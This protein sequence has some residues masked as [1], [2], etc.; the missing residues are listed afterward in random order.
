[1][2]QLDDAHAA[3]Q[4]ER[5]QPALTLDERLVAERT[6]RSATSISRRMSSSL[7]AH[8]AADQHVIDERA[9]GPPRCVHVHVD[10][11]RL[12]ARRRSRPRRDVCET[13]VADRGARWRRDRRRAAADKTAV[14]ASAPSSGRRLRLVD[15]AA[16][17]AMATSPITCGVP[18]VTMQA[19]GDRTVLPAPSAALGRTVISRL[20]HGAREPAHAIQSRSPPT[21]RSRR[22]CRRTAPPACSAQERREL[23][24]ATRASLPATSSDASRCSGPRLTVKV[25]TISPPRSSRTYGASRGAVALLAQEASMLRLASS[26]RSRSTLRSWRIGTSVVAP[27]LGQRIAGEHDAGRAA[28]ARRRASRSATCSSSANVGA[29][30]DV[31]LVVALLAQLVF[32]RE[33]CASRSPTRS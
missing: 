27:I 23:G 11:R 10:A 8:V 15:S 12:V 19:D 9:A 2:R 30:R 13:L 5:R 16:R 25:S 22:G 17:P 29:M 14:P 1:M 26:S 20:D 31:G 33:Q 3:K 28:R 6:A 21:R 4:P 18:S 7:G 32:E 24:S